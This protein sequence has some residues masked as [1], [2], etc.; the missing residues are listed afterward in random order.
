MG[1]MHAHHGPSQRE[2]ADM[3]ALDVCTLRNLA[4]GRYLPDPVGTR[5]M[6]VFAQAPDGVKDALYESAPSERSRA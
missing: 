5:V 4:Q 2:Y 6:Q 1:D 3:G